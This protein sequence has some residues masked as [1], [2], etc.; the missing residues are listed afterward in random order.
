M[1]TRC[2]WRERSVRQKKIMS[3]KPETVFEKQKP[4][5]KHHFNRKKK[6]LPTLVSFFSHFFGFLDMTK[7][8]VF[9]IIFYH[10]KCTVFG[11][12]LPFPLNKLHFILDFCLKTQHLLHFLL[13]FHPFFTIFMTRCIKIKTN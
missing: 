12:F 7:N 10:P 9:F 4:L 11:S 8:S 2:G 6:H 3:K 1:D 5:S 13:G